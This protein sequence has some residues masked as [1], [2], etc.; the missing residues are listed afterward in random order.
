MTPER[1]QRVKELF[2]S[3]LEGE[4][5]QRAT[6]LDKAC[7]GDPSLRRQVEALLASHEQAPSF[8]E[9]PRFEM[10]ATYFTEDETGSIL[11]RRIGA[12]ELLREIGHGGM[13]AVY[14]AV[15]ADDE[16]QKR[17]AIKLVKRG[18]DTNAVLRRHLATRWLEAP[19]SERGTV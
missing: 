8:L 4:G 10:V 9:D 5:S 19:K 7:A 18:M 17:V 3:A 12:Y 13:G 11:G 2:Q 16:Y 15:R 6:F 14:L 1:W